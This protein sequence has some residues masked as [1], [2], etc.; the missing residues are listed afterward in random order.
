MIAQAR[1]DEAQARQQARAGGSAA[2]QGQE[3]YWEY[4]QRQMAE[5]TEKLGLMGDSVNK[6][7]ETS[8]GWAD[9]AGKFVQKQKKQMIMG[10]K[11]VFR[12]DSFQQ[13]LISSIAVKGRLG[14]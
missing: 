8:S 4:M 13:V 5:R 3:G 2:N 6:L 1:S 10:G 9:A 12:I 14:L 11:C 7:E